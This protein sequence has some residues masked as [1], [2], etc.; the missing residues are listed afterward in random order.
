MEMNDGIAFADNM[1][2]MYNY[3]SSKTYPEGLT[4]DQNTVLT[5]SHYLIIYF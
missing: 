5:K 1:H 2:N 3:C 4:R